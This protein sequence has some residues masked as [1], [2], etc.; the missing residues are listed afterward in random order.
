MFFGGPRELSSSI[1]A[2]VRFE[3]WGSSDCRSAAPSLPALYVSTIARR[4]PN[5]A[6]GLHIPSVAAG[7]GRAPP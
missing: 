4:G 6:S 2:T 5:I 1:P 3:R 7:G